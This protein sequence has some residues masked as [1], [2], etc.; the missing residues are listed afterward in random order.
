[1]PPGGTSSGQT[2]ALHVNG[3][4][5]EAKPTSGQMQQYEWQVP[6]SAWLAGTNELW[7]HASR[8]VRPADTGGE[9][10]RRLAIAVRSITLRP[11]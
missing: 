9:D 2:V 7:F 1:M 10:P 6:A 8:A 3:I 4:E 11:R 5:L